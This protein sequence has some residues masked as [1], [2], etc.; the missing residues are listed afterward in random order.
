MK[1][2]NT[3]TWLLGFSL[4]TATVGGFAQNNPEIPRLTVSSPEAAAA[5]LQEFPATDPASTTAAFGEFAKLALAGIDEQVMLRVITNTPDVYKLGVDQ[6]LWLRDVGVSKEVINA[7]MA[8]DIEVD[9]RQVAQAL[10]TPSAPVQI[11]WLASWLKSPDSRATKTVAASS[12]PK[13]STP[14]SP[15]ASVTNRIPSPSPAQPLPAATEPA[16]A[17]GGRELNQAQSVGEVSPMGRNSPE[18]AEEPAFGYQ[19]NPY[20]VRLPYPVKLLD[21]II[22][23][24]APW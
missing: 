15:S 13:T 2:R 4:A 20:P 21:P 16:K 18:Q 19:S 10:A 22:I 7:M 24:V 1:M 14:S 9:T 3:A 5:L 11:A 23:M 8:H 6:I 17:L 12:Q